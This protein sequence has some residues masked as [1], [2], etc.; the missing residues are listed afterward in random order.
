MVE[1]IIALST[2]PGRSGIAVVR[3][4]GARALE[5]ARKLTRQTDFQPAPRRAYLKQIFVDADGDS[6]EPIDAALITYFAQPNSFTGEDVIEISSHGSPVIARQIIDAALK[7]D[8]RLAQAGE[9]TLRALSNGQLNLAQAEAVRD[10]IDANT[11]AAARQAARQ[12][13]GELSNQLQPLKDKLLN[14][15]VVLESALEFVEDDLPDVAQERIGQNLRE[16]K[17]ELSKLADTFRAGRLLREGLKVALVGR[18][19]VGKSSLFN[20]L[21]GRERAIVTAIAGT[22]RDALFEN[23]IIKGV[24]VALIDTAGVRETVDAVEKIGVERTR[25]T[26]ADADL[27]IVIL[28]ATQKLTQEDRQIL[29]A[30]KDALR[31]IA[32]NKTDLPTANFD[33]SLLGANAKIV[34]ISAKTGF[35]LD[36]LQAQIVAPFAAQNLETADFL[37]SDARHHDLLR[38]AES[39]IETSLNLLQAKTSEEITLVGLH[40]ALRLLGEITGETTSEDVLTRIFETFCIGK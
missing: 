6:I 20:A 15:I 30:T 26:I 27:I 5:I 34:S 38:R 17:N 16:I 21:L 24:A 22:T 3:L 13:G 37:I 2:P 4:S 29:T 9:F 8:A 7:S 36:E 39:E 14:Q 23:L 19:N 40:N 11:V 12:L 1:T 18:P 33:F 31:I 32:L 10:L 35:N 28:D 25:Q